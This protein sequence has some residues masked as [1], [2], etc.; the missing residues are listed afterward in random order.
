MWMNSGMGSVIEWIVILK[1][2]IIS[3]RVINWLNLELLW[4]GWGS[5]VQRKMLGFLEQ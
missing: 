2:G 5:Q 3:Y 4:M 1:D